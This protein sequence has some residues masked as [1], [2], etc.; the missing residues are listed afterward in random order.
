MT[1][2]KPYTYWVYHKPSRRFYYGSRTANGCNTADLWQSYFTSSNI[3]KQLIEK[4][5]KDSFICR[6]HKTFD[7]KEECLQYEY[8]LLRR[9]KAG[10]NTRFLNLHHC[11][12]VEWT[13]ERLQK[14][15]HTKTGVKLSEAHKKAI[16]KGRTG[17]T[18]I[19]SEDWVKK[20]ARAR[21]G[22][23]R[24]S[25]TKYKMKQSRKARCK[26]FRFTNLTTMQIFQGTV[27]EFVNTY[28]TYKYGRVYTYCKELKQL[29]EWQIVQ[30]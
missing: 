24:S 7:T 15:S 30:L 11:K 28:R 22:L 16:S 23:K 27:T 9:Y 10:T 21:T 26:I 5:G 25:N 2:Y 18:V 1:I 6:I 29:D 17:C 3:V 8:N 12:S 19:Q 20:A 14:L 13:P 4:D